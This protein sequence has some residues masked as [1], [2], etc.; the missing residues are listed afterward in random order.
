M[1]LHQCFDFANYRIFLYNSRLKNISHLLCHCQ[2]ISTFY[3]SYHPVNIRMRRNLIQLKALIGS[4][5]GNIDSGLTDQYK[6]VR[7]LSDPGQFLPDPLCQ[8]SSSHHT[9]RNICPDIHSTIHQLLLAQSQFKKPVDPHQCSCRIRASACHTCCHRNKFLKMDIHTTL[10]LKF[11]HQK[12]RRL[13]HQISFI[14]RNIG[15]IDRQGNPRLPHP[16]HLQNIIHLYRLHDHPDFMIAI[17]SLSENI[18][19]QIYLRQCT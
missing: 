14:I 1:T 15:I 13:I 9:V 3:I 5:G 16:L 19:S 7:H 11:I 10:N 6:T 4:F 18:Q 12:L 8:G 2:K 17:L